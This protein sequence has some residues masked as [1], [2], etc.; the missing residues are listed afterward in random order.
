MLASPGVADI[1]PTE[2]VKAR[3]LAIHS[4]PPGTSGDDANA[5]WVEI[6]VEQNSDLANWRV[7]HVRALWREEVAKPIEW[8]WIYTFGSPHFATAGEIY[9]I[10][11]GSMIRAAM[12]PLPDDLA[13]GRKHV[14]VAGP[15]GA[16][17]LRFVKGDYLRLVEAFGTVIDE[18]VVW[19]EPAQQVTPEAEPARR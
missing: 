6:R 13:P 7:A 15:V 12:H 8:E 2:S 19:P 10:H 9:R 4:A 3:I 14:Y 11:S 1:L 5:E 17:R 16:A 18:I